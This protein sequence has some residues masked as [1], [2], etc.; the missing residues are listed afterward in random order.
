MAQP[1]GCSSCQA[2]T[3]SLYRPCSF[4]ACLT[5]LVVASWRIQDGDWGCR[6]AWHRTH[7]AKPHRQLTG[8][9][10]CSPAL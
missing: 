1:V 5:A 7:T 10:L 3:D 9:A 4:S 6:R 2:M 8:F